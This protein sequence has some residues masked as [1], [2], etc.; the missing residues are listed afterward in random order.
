MLILVRFCARFFA[1]RRQYRLFTSRKRSSISARRIALLNEIGFS[2]NAQETAWEKHVLCLMKFKEQYG[3]CNVPVDNTEYPKL[4]FWVKE[5][6]RH[7]GLMKKGKPSHM[8]LQRS[9][10]LE[11]L[12]FC[13]DT[14]QA[15][16]KKRLNEMAEFKAKHG[17]CAVPVNYP[18]NPQLGTWA[19]HQRRQFRLFKEGKEARITPE[20]VR[21]LE[22]IGFMWNPASHDAEVLSSCGEE[23]DVE[24]ETES[25]RSHKRQKIMGNQELL[26]RE[27]AK[28]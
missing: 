5:Q 19:L 10:Q 21:T 2:W 17:H 16:W 12:G 22:A 20:R 18:E 4:G 27:P 13:W 9:K 11:R 26:G 28:G 7:Y 8:T 23:S 1:P 24:T 15:T 6:R 14:H 25:E 3:H